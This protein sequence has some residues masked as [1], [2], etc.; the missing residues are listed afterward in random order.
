MDIDVGKRTRGQYFLLRR[1]GKGFR[2]ED[3]YMILGTETKR[4]S[5]RGREEI[6]TT[7][8]EMT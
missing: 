8:G 3:K 4:G 2:F 1:T 7:E 6:A 5:K